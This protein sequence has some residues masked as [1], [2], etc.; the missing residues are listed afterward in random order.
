[1]TPH[2]QLMLHQTTRCVAL[3]GLMP[4]APTATASCGVWQPRICCSTLPHH[5]THNKL[6]AKPKRQVQRQQ[7][8]VTNDQLAAADTNTTQA[9]PSASASAPAPAG[10]PTS[11]N[12]F[13]ALMAAAKGGGGSGGSGSAQKKLSA[14]EMQQQADRYAH[15]GSWSV[16]ILS[17]HTT[18]L[19]LPHIQHA[20]C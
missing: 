3:C 15:F 17:L 11:G 5:S 2:N 9:A 1:M 12:A 18:H 10:G 6:Q 20:L 7:D 8:D 16:V 13:G 19:N 4:S 14:Q